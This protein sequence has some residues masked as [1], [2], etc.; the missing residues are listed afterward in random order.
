M[1]QIVKYNCRDSQIQIGQ[2][3]EDRESSS[4]YCFSLGSIMIS[5]LSR[6]QTSI[7]FSATEAE[8]IATWLASCEVEWLHKLLASLFDQVQVTTMMIG[9]STMRYSTKTW[10]KREQYGSSTILQSSKLLT[11]SLSQNEVCI[12]RGK[13]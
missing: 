5:W 3:V 7:A 1:S 2:S 12:L 8:Y 4:K 13:V 10:Y 11:K 6:K 9:Q